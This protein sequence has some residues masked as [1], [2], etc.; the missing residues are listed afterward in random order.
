MK[1]VLQRVKEAAVIVEGRVV[2]EIGIG[3]LLLVGFTDSDSTEQLEWM[4]DKILGLRVFNDQDDKMNLD[5][6]EV[7]GS[8]LV[9]SQFTLY[10]DVKKGRRPSFIHAA[11]PDIAVLLYQEFIDLL[12]T[13]LPGR[14]AT[15]QFGA[16]MD[17]SLI[18][19]GPVTLMLEK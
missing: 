18:N 14:V 11:S 8:L 13:R 15:G 9:V 4:A 10:G 2:G 7:D 19:D 16:V 12:E 17:V 1:V 6:G 5:L 3:Y